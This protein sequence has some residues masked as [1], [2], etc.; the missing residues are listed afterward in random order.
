MSMFHAWNIAP[1]PLILLDSALLD[2]AVGMARAL[3]YCISSAGSDGKGMVDDTGVGH[4]RAGCTRDMIRF[5]VGR[6]KQNE[7]HTYR[8]A[9]TANRVMCWRS[10]LPCGIQDGAS[11]QTLPYS[12]A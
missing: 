1:K 9:P 6:S 5:P 12:T 7:S 8:K 11:R 4:A 3:H 2:A 10:T